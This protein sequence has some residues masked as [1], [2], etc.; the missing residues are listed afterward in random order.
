MPSPLR[1]QALVVS[2]PTRRLSASAAAFT[3]LP[4]VRPLNPLAGVFDPPSVGRTK[5]PD[6][7]NSIISP[8][9]DVMSSPV[10]FTSQVPMDSLKPTNLVQL[11]ALDAATQHCAFSPEKRALEANDLHEHWGAEPAPALL[12][13]PE[14]DPVSLHSSTTSTKDP[15]LTCS[16]LYLHPRRQLTCSA[17][18]LDW[19]PT[20]STA[21]ACRSASHIPCSSHRRARQRSSMLPSASPTPY[22]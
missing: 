8:V 7:A 18:V 4:P 21:L 6:E 9:D 12:P 15:A 5:L 17:T 10:P 3:P 19:P 20:R 14:P 13:L 11:A 1:A 2:P 22:S 16:T